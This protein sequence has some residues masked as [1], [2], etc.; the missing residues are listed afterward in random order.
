MNINS[1]LLPTALMAAVITISASLTSCG[2][3]HIDD[4]VPPTQ[5]E[6]PKA[7]SPEKPKDA[8]PEKP[9]ELTPEKPKDS[10]P[11]QPKDTEPEK[12]K[13]E[14][15]QTPKDPTPKTNGIE[16]T[17]IFSEGKATFATVKDGR[18]STYKVTWSFDGKN[19]PQFLLEDGKKPEAQVQKIL[20]SEDIY[21]V[22]RQWTFG[23]SNMLKETLYDI[24]HS[25]W[26]AEKTGTYNYYSQRKQVYTTLSDGTFSALNIEKIQENVLTITDADGY[27]WDSNSKKIYNIHL[28]FKRVK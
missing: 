1:R 13:E 20:E 27:P 3:D 24:K 15:P 14:K 5:K 22:P 4:I 18:V 8:E 12:P 7:G 11:E 23:P 28:T 21:V 25:K 17:W 6:T 9:K 19:K 16:G 10:T 26:G 2:K